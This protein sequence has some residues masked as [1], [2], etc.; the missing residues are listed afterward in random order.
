MELKSINWFALAG[1]IL[2][3]IL[4][5]LSI[6]TPWWILKIGT[7][8]GLATI[9]ADPFYTNFSFLGLNL[10]VPI[11]FAI[12]VGIMALFAISGIILIIY[13]FK[14]NRDYS[15]HL[16]SYGW[17]RPIYTFVGFFATLTIILYVLPMIIN[18]TKGTSMLP[19]PIMPLI[20]TTVM[21]LPTS[22]LGSGS[23]SS[24]IQI[25]VT[26]I[27]AFTY[28]FYLGMAAAVLGIMA[29]IYHSRIAPKMVVA[30]QSVPLIPV[31]PVSQPTQ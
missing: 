9:N 7:G 26:V 24:G 6:F 20:G 19:V 3:L 13:T 23:G 27:T 18:T 1:G 2:M 16:L 29:R 22:M 31:A 25:G 28:T 5:A 15:K 4:V 14:P 30:R 12:N 21:Q 8:N 11:L 17:K 10:V